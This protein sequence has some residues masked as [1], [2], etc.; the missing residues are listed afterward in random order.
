[1]FDELEQVWSTLFSFTPCLLQAACFNFRCLSVTSSKNPSW[2]RH[3]RTIGRAG[4]RR[5]YPYSARR[6]LNGKGGGVES[7]KFDAE[8]ADNHD[9][10]GAHLVRSCMG[11]PVSKAERASVEFSSPRLCSGSIP[12]HTFFAS[13]LADDDAGAYR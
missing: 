12:R 2:R 9:R 8:T 1:M 13:S 6:G 7:R 4:S 11:W 5:R 3:G 10:I